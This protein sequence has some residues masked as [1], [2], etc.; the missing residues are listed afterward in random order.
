MPSQ[1]CRTRFNN[2]TMTSPEEVLGIVKGLADVVRDHHH[3]SKEVTNQTQQQIQEL[4]HAVTDLSL[5]IRARDASPHQSIRLPPLSLPQF[6]GAEPIDRFA[7]QLTQVLAT[8]GVSPRLW[9]TYLKQQSQKDSRAFD[10]I[11]AFETSNATKF[12]SK[13]T[14]DEFRTLYDQCLHNLCSQRGIPKEEQLRQLL[15]VYYSMRQQ[16][17]ESVSNFAHRF[18][19]TQHSLEKLLPGIHTSPDGQQL[20]LIHAFAM[21]LHPPIAKN[22]LSR[23]EP[24]KSL[25]AIIEAAKRH[26]SVLPS[27]DPLPKALFAEPNK[28][29]PGSGMKNFSSSSLPSQICRNFNK[30]SHSHCQL[31]GNNCRFKRLHKCLKCNKFAC[32]E[33][34]HEQHINSPVTQAST[35]PRHRNFVRHTPKVSAHTA[36]SNSHESVLLSSVKQIVND[37][38]VDLRQELTTSIKREVEKCLPQPSGTPFS[39]SADSSQDPLFGMPAITALPTKSTISAIDLANKNILWTKVSSAGVSLPLP[40]DSCCSVSLVSQKHAD[41]VAKYNSNFQFTKLEQHIP[42]SVAGPCSALRAVG[43]MQVPIVWENGR[44]TTF[45]MLVVPNL[46]W[47]I[48][49]GQNHL[50]QT[51]AIIRSRELTVY[52]A[53]KAMDFEVKCNDSNP[54]LAFPSLD[55]SRPGSIANVTCLLTAKPTLT[56]SPNKVYLERGFNLVTVCFF[57]AASLVGSPLFSGPLWLEGNRFSP[58]LETLSGPIDLHSVDNFFFPGETPPPFLTANRP[59][60]PKCRPSRPIPPADQ[61]CMGALFSAGENCVSSAANPICFQ[62][63]ILIR[64]TKGKAVLPSNI[65]LGSIRTPHAEDI[66]VMECAINHTANLVSDRCCAALAANNSM[67]DIPVNQNSASAIHSSGQDST[68]LADFLD[69]NLSDHEHALPPTDDPYLDPSSEM[70][71]TELC[72]ALRIDTPSYAHVP[73]DI[74]SKFKGLLKRFPRAFYLPNSPLS[75][76]KGFHHNIDTGNA[77]PVYKLPYRKSPAELAAIKTEIER[78]LRLRI[79][80]PSHS[81]W[82][83]HISYR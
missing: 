9:L 39:A 42:V 49:F 31:P 5:S 16:P 48:L 15:A 33:I 43:T 11:C 8:S 20:E 4:S 17:H 61:Y 83:A 30:F 74:M 32:K 46:T 76:I 24:F 23:D 78:M 37:S 77:S 26:E 27:T 35:T 67:P 6:T 40:L 10:I 29:P 53:N 13:T 66:Q 1:K 45:T 52:F 55:F 60:H 50:R 51:D 69:R 25:P 58:G 63:H 38:L 19:E 22:L 28:A 62:A 14:P 70:F 75:P 73:Q 82:G 3:S 7:E 81:P 54:A 59:T 12:T 71:F 47:P 57:I 21:K 72:N 34:Y 56:G 80:E 79:I 65:S 68:L 36:A 64:S 18:L 41:T 2:T 44:S